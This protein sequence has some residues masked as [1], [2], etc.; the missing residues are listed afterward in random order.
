MSD[1]FAKAMRAE[2]EKA[3][4][5]ELRA[6]MIND[7]HA[8]SPSLGQK[9]MIAILLGELDPPNDPL[10]KYRKFFQHYLQENERYLRDRLTGCCWEC[11]TCP[12][13]LFLRCLVESG[14]AKRLFDKERN[15]Q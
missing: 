13:E 11:D 14:Q 6:L 1:E 10:S 5:P 4:L 9:E 7:G 15:K 8:V 12:T 3:S 2:Y